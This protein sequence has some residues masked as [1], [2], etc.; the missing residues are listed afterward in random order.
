MN[1]ASNRHNTKTE[2]LSLSKL[3]S[4]GSHFNFGKDVAPVWPCK[5]ARKDDTGTRLFMLCI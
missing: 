2:D 3:I 5:Q 1:T 4:S